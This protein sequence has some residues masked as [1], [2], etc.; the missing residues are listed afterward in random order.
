MQRRKTNEDKRSP[1]ATSNSDKDTGHVF[2]GQA[3]QVE[4][5]L[6]FP[7]LKKP[8]NQPSAENQQQKPHRATGLWYFLDAALAITCEAR[9]KENPGIQGKS[10]LKSLSSL[11]SG[12]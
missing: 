5:F 4:R 7:S 2:T 6:Y 9:P 10:E 1:S 12:G 11:N 3:F 8:N